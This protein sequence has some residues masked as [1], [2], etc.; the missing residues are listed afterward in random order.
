MLRRVKEV[1]YSCPCLTDTTTYE[2]NMIE[3]VFESAQKIAQERP[4]GRS[5]SWSS[6]RPV[7]WLVGWSVDRLVGWL[8]GR[9]VGWCGCLFGCV[10]FC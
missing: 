7:G 2:M 3:S 10:L 4:V 8:V 1:G 5:V 6:G 9:S